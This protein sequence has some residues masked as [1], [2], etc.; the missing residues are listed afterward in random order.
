MARKGGR[1]GKG[2]PKLFRRV[3]RKYVFAPDPDNPEFS[4]ALGLVAALV[5]KGMEGDVSAINTL[6][7][8]VDPPRAKHVE[9]RH[10]LARSLVIAPDDDVRALP[11]DVQPQLPSGEPP[12]LSQPADV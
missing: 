7:G 4:R 2:K 3:A 1:A 12:D 5:R 6:V 11:A 8:L 10:S 9:H